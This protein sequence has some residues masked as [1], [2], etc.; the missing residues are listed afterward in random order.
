MG[1]YLLWVLQGRIKV[2]LMGRLSLREV[3]FKERIFYIVLILFSSYELLL[4]QY[5]E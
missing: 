5:K 2:L 4:L 3:R 1:G